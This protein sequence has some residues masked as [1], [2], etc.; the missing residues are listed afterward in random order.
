MMRQRQLGI[1][2]TVFCL[3]CPGLCG[4]IFAWKC[5][6]YGISWK[7]RRKNQILTFTRFAR[8]LVYFEA[9]FFTKTFLWPYL[10]YM[11]GKLLMWRLI[12]CGLLWYLKGSE[13]K[14]QRRT[15]IRHNRMNLTIF[16]KMCNFVWY[17]YSLCT[18]PRPILFIYFA[19]S[20]CWILRPIIY[21]NLKSIFL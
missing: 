20:K 1:G 19:L 17:K 12:V 8:Y 7:I 2:V 5:I 11:V 13:F 9:L 18:D 3:S 6:F 4:L 15:Q 16:E 21:F 10:S 14:R